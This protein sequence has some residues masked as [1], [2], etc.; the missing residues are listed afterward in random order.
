MQN[1]YLFQ[2][3]ESGTQNFYTTISALCEAHPRIS[4]NVSES[5]L[6]RIDFSVN[7]YEN[8]LCLIKSVPLKKKSDV[9]K[10]KEQQAKTDATQFIW[11]SNIME[12]PEHCAKMFSIRNI[13]NELGGAIYND[14]CDE[15]LLVVQKGELLGFSGYDK[16]GDNFTFKRAYVFE[17]YRGF[18]VY[19]EMFK[20]RY[21]KAKELGCKVLQAKTSIMS[22]RLFI[23][24]GFMTMDTMPRKFVVYRKML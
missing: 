19:N 3:K 13:A 17:Q 15:W 7:N 9:L 18:G 6:R 11:T 21:Q 10:E 14:N 16:R 23:N 22:R 12:Y 1:I 8:D 4:I 2:N 5:T 20:L 24:N